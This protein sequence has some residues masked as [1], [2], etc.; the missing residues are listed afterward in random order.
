M[1]D[2][3]V[4]PTPSPRPQAAARPNPPRPGRASPP[5]SIT[6][7]L[8]NPRWWASVLGTDGPDKVLQ[9]LEPLSAADKQ[10][11][12]KKLDD[13]F[14]SDKDKAP[15]IMLRRL[16]RF[17]L[18][19]SAT[20][21]NRSDFTSDFSNAEQL[22]TAAPAPIGTVKLHRRVHVKE[23]VPSTYGESFDAYG[24]TFQ[25]DFGVETFRWLQ[26]IW[27]RVVATVP[28]G[29][30]KTRKIARKKKDVHSQA[31]YHYTTDLAPKPKNPNWTTDTG[32]KTTAFYEDGTTVKRTAT[33]LALFDFPTMDSDA[34]D[35]LGPGGGTATEVV[36]EFHAATYLVRGH[37]VLYRV[38]VDVSA[39][40]KKDPTSGTMS[41]VLAPVL[42][43]GAPAN[44][45]EAGQRACLAVQHPEFDYFP[46]PPIG[47]PLPMDE[48]DPIV[49]LKLGNW[50]D[51]NKDM[52]SRY[53]D[54]VDLAGATVITD[55]DRFIP[56][57]GRVVAGLNLSSQVAAGD[58]AGDAGYI[59]GAGNH[60]GGMDLPVDRF[61]T[62]PRVA[63]RLAPKAFKFAGDWREKPF[64]VSVMR[65][66]MMHAVHNEMAIGWLLKWRDEITAT[67]FD[68]W[69]MGELSANR[70]SSVD[71]QL[72]TT[73]T[74]K[75][76]V[77][78]QGLAHMEGFLTAMP[79]LPATPTLKDMHKVEKWPAALIELNGAG[80]NFGALL[81][82]PGG[83]AFKKLADSRIH[84]YCRV[85]GITPSHRKAVID[86]LDFMDN[87]PAP[88]TQNEVQAI[89]V[90][91]DFHKNK[92]LLNS[93]RDACK[94]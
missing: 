9:E 72:V 33:L 40:S 60:H 14:A 37:E 54:V 5:P 67:P 44:E 88:Q 62:L 46:G 19:P 61:A 85:E 28:A 57:S 39:T 3:L 74:R 10:D 6:R 48:F 94:P 15:A 21:P 23:K 32:I 63:I 24:I 65:H 47:A 36:S 58:E 50:A 89:R 38:D 8:K 22:R 12:A 66:E 26:F 91:K 83:D 29:Q 2:P 18:A 71:F 82:S 13:V 16:I 34:R 43:K 75:V 56:R 93:I 81:G 76:V 86:W 64:S 73:G 84:A 31:R 87:P 79:F 59:D 4:K 90:I 35:L 70:I 25:H 49:D 78:T 53:E 7:D 51:N 45:L 27:R 42:M 30:G 52:F 17:A 55:V 92:D 80:P 1:A 68:R 41:T 11:L 69:I 20:P 77:A